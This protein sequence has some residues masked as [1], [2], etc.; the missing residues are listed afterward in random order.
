MEPS[1]NRVIDAYSKSGQSV[2]VMFVM[3]MNRL[4]FIMSEDNEAVVVCFKGL[5]EEFLRKVTGNRR[6]K[7]NFYPIDEET[8]T[9]A[10][11]WE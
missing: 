3:D 7:I 6:R 10:L 11:G 1:G 8:I 2:Y 4:Q 5:Q 9:N